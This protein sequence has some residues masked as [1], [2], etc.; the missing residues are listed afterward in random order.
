[1]AL[2]TPTQVVDIAFTNKNTDKYLVK[3]AFVEIA[4]LNFIQP[5]IGEDLYESILND[6]A[7]NVSWNSVPDIFDEI[8]CSADPASILQNKYIQ[9]F[10]ANNY[11]TVAVYFEYLTAPVPAILPTPPG[12][13]GVIKV[14]LSLTPT[15]TAIEMSNALASAINAAGLGLGSAVADG[16]N[17]VT[18]TRPVNATPPDNKFSVMNSLLSYSSYS[19]FSVTAASNTITCAANSFIQVGDFVSGSNIPLR[20]DGVEGCRALNTVLTVDTPGA[21]TS[22]TIS[23]T[24]TITNALSNVLFQKPNGKLVDEFIV[25]YLAFAVR[26][27]M[28]P[29]MAYNTTSQGL[30]E[31]TA[32][33]SLP[34]DAKTLSFM[35]GE[36]YKKSE[37][38]LRKMKDF[39][40]E[41]SL[42]YPLYC[43]DNSSGV[44]KL[45]GIILY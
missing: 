10:S 39:L 43:D 23:G 4:E 44:T 13:N 8:I 24:P 35:R 20:E 2:I 27:E 14:D 38:Y 25:N 17:K 32:A 45:N 3:P 9:M 7:T 1:M 11:S 33:F 42:S 34:V 37:T 29:D 28:I 18:I 41:N 21:V 5:A 26:F 12:F 30:V 36:T 40:E 16:I 22:F 15:P 31:S 19:N 6:K